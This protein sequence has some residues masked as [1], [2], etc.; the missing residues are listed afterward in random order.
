MTK[1]D[2]KTLRG[3]LA[4]A[5]QGPLT[6]VPDPEDDCFALVFAPTHAA[7]ARFVVRMED[8]TTDAPQTAQKL[9]TA[10]L[11]IAAISALPALLDRSD[12]LDRVKAERD[13]ALKEHTDMMWQRRRADE[14]AEAAEPAIA[15]A[16]AAIQN[17]GMMLGSTDEWSDQANMIG[18]V[19][20]RVEELKAGAEAWKPM[21]RA[22]EAE[23][24][25]LQA[26]LSTAMRERDEARRAMQF[27]YYRPHA[28]IGS[29]RCT[30]EYRALYQHGDVRV[31]YVNEGEFLMFEAARA[32][33]SP[34]EPT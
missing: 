19:T 28:L 18:D 23:N 29:D 14:R 7:F 4:K 12:E 17:I 27:K 32:A 33:L 22:L 21:T 34:K 2:T 5:T 9:A 15:T 3:M 26:A 1:P 8:D 30:A 6:L 25:R 31:V 10:K 13:E 20:R 16:D 11:Y 24:A